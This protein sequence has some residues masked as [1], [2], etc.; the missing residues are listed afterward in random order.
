MLQQPQPDDYVVATGVNTSVREMCRLAFE[1][2]GLDYRDYVK[3]DPRY[4][5]PAEVDVLLGNPNKARTVLG[6]QPRTPLPELI[7]LM[8]EADLRRLR[9][10]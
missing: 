4:L 3:T 5:R 8:V 6:W 7:G 1:R 2:V 10:D 9:T